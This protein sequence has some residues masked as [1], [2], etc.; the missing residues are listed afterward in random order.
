MF[1]SCFL[2]IN[3]AATMLKVVRT[4][5]VPQE[6]TTA[7]SNGEVERSIRRYGSKYE[8]STPRSKKIGILD[9]C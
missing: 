6:K 4:A 2:R 9:V 1:K 7:D 3:E 5:P 8:S